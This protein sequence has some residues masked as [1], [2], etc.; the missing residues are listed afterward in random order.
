M[1]D[2][3]QYAILVHLHFVNA[4]IHI[5][6][7]LGTHLYANHVFS[8]FLWQTVG[9]LR[10]HFPTSK[11]FPGSL[12]AEIWELKQTVFPFNYQFH[13]MRGN[14]E[15]MYMVYNAYSYGPIIDGIVS[16]R[17]RLMEKKKFIVRVMDPV[18]LCWSLPMRR[19][20]AKRSLVY[21]SKSEF[22]LSM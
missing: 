8:L 1:W 2:K 16:G 20:P 15:W 11:L 12:S 18:F 13:S 14:I 3:N 6:C 22:L 17:M 10:G 7:V 9:Y 19:C 21:D 4:P 5:M